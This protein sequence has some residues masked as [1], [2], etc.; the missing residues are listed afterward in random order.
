MTFIDRLYF[1]E[2]QPDNKLLKDS[3]KFFLKYESIPC[4]IK[5]PVLCITMKWLKLDKKFPV[6]FIHRGETAM[7]KSLI[8]HKKI[9]QEYAEKSSRWYHEEYFKLL[10]NQQALQFDRNT[11]KE[12]MKNLIALLNI[13]WNEAVFAANWDEKK[14]VT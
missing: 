8:F 4:V 13:P 1:P 12:Q 11:Y 7:A 2:L 9:D 14:I 5:E 6:V 3:L 10:K